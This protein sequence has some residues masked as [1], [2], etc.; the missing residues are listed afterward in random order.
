MQAANDFARQIGGTVG[1]TD[2]FAMTQDR[3]TAFGGITL[4]FD[5]HHID[6]RQAEHGPFGKPAAQG[7]LTLSLLTHFIEQM[8]RHPG[9]A[10]H[11]NYGLNKVRFIRPVLVGENI[12]AAFVL[13]DVTV[14]DDNGALLSWDVT[15]E[16]EGH[17][18]PAMTA[19]WLVVVYE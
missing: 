14:R 12:R 13:R 7:F 6:P 16:S 5:P 9:I 17:D 2:W 15:V 8:P 11:V 1:R 3:I 10:Q 4:D 19:Q 18:K